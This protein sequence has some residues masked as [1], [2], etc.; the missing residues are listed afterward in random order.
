MQR[1]SNGV[2]PG[3]MQKRDILPRDVVIAVLLPECRRP[4]RSKQLQHQRADLTRR[5]KAVLEQPHITLWHH[6]IAQ[7]CSAKKERFAGGIDNLFVVRVRELRFPLRSP[8]QKK[9]RQQ[10]KSEL[11]HDFLPP[12]AY[13]N[14]LPLKQS[15][16]FPMVTQD[17]PP[18]ARVGISDHRARPPCLL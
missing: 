5:L 12:K 17:S 8:C 18:S 15:P 14:L 4:F 11:E 3:A 16:S 1:D 6:P 9:Q 13:T 7:V 2:E 10:K